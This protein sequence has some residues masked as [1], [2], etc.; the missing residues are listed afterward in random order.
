MTRHGSHL[1]NFEIRVHDGSVF[2]NAHALAMLSPYFEKVCFDES[3]TEAN[4]GC[5]EVKDVDLNQITIFLSYVLPGDDFLYHKTIDGSNLA[6][7]I[8]LAERFLFPSVRHEIE[9][10]LVDGV[11]ANEEFKKQCS[12][13]RDLGSKML[14]LQKRRNQVSKLI[15]SLPPAEAKYVQEQVARFTLYQSPSGYPIS[16][17]AWNDFNVRMFF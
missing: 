11:F 6:V 1:K 9:A 4:C 13:Q 14:Q 5:V 17:Y 15:T 7:L 12:H 3:F 16:A 10:F 8:Q 2:V